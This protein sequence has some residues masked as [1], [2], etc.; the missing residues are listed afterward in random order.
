MDDPFSYYLERAAD[1]GLGIELDHLPRDR[2]RQDVHRRYDDQRNA[3][4]P[5]KVISYFSSA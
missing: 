4:R 2:V 5:E 3:G 1:Q